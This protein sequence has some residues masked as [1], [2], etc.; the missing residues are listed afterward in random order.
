[1]K[2]NLKT[3]LKKILYFAEMLCLKPVN[4]VLIEF[5]KKNLFNLYCCVFSLYVLIFLII[6]T[7]TLIQNVYLNI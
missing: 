3:N 1:M 7:Y 6:K 5:K 2:K 4:P